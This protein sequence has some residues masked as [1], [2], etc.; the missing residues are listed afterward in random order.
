MAECRQQE[1]AEV[2]GAMRCPHYSDQLHRP[3]H[4]DV[5]EAGWRVECKRYKGGIGSKEVE[6]ILT[7]DQG[8]HAVVHRRDFGIP[9]VTLGL[10]D[11]LDLLAGETMPDGSGRGDP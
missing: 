10:E 4:C 5:A 7:G 11:W 3:R 8:V 9:L 1:R 2:E 6:G